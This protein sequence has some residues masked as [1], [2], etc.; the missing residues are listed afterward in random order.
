MTAPVQDMSW[1]RW[2]QQTKPEVHDCV[3]DPTPCP[4]RTEAGEVCGI[5]EVCLA[6]QESDPR[7]ARRPADGP[8]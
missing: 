6:A 8:S 4:Q 2:C 1:C 5:C 3:G 7:Y